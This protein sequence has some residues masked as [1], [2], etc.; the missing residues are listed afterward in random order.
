MPLK[1][2]A[3]VLIPSSARPHF[4]YAIAVQEQ[5]AQLLHAIAMR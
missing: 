2:I 3:L 5:V 1:L 4:I